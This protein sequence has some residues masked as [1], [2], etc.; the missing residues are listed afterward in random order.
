MA[1]ATLQEFRAHGLPGDALASLPPENIEA[2]LTWASRT[3]DSYLRKRH[4]L[5]LVEWS[6]DL[7]GAVCSIA[8]YELLARRG[9]RPGPADEIVI[10]RYNDSITWLR[11]VAKGVVEID[12]IDSTPTVDEDGSLAAS[13]PKVSFRFQTVGDCDDG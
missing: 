12:A 9:F 7:R 1:Y 5:P 2:A 13:G 8:Q 10:K 6:D 4:T 11:D 3:A